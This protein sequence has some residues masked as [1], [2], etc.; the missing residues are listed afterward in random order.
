[1]EDDDIVEHCKL[2]ESGLTKLLMWLRQEKLAPIGYGNGYASDWRTIYCGS[3]CST[4]WVGT[5][6]LWA[7]S[8]DQERLL[9]LRYWKA[10]QLPCDFPVHSLWFLSPTRKVLLGSKLQIKD[11]TW[12]LMICIWFSLNNVFSKPNSFRKFQYNKQVRYDLD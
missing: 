4:H 3:S 11:C 7:C 5:G 6:F 10:L 2:F 9:W 8:L 1:M 12:H